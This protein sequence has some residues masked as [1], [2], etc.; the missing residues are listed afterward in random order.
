MNITYQGKSGLII[1]QLHGWYKV[2]IGD[3]ILFLYRDE[4]E[5]GV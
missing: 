5:I 1:D 4:F 3:D 2:R